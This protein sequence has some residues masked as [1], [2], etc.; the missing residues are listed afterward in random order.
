VSDQVP[1]PHFDA[2]VSRSAVESLARLRTGE[3]TDIRELAVV[4]QE[5]PDF[6][7]SILR[8][9]NA[10]TLGLQ[11][12][13]TSPKHAM[14]MLGTSRLKDLVDELVEQNKTLRSTTDRVAQSQRK[15]GSD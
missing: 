7:S 14:A 4:A 11:H 8:A 2:P 10:S 3:E 12:P 5:F 9:A 1:R 13:I 15:E 6:R